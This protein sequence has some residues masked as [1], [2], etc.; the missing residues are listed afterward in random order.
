MQA[1][2]AGRRCALSSALIADILIR[3][4][5]MTVPSTR[6][7]R[8]EVR[9]IGFDCDIEKCAQVARRAARTLIGSVCAL[10]A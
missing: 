10:A 2:D 9:A 8:F 7:T 1:I 5:G 6:A 3:I 4:T